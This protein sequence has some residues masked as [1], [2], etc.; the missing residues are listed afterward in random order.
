MAVKGRTHRPV[1]RHERCN[2]CAVCL[3]GCPAEILPEMRGEE[4]SLRGRVYSRRDGALRVHEGKDLG[5]PP[6]QAACPLG[7]DVRG[8]IKLIAE[9]RHADAMALIRETNPL[10]SICGHICPRPCEA[11]CIRGLVDDAVSIRSLKSFVADREG[12]RIEL[13]FKSRAVDKRVSVVGSGP[14]GLSAAHE[15]AA[16][17]YGVEIFESH[18]R[19]GGMLAWAIPDFR[20]PRDALDRDISYIEEMGVMIKTG[21]CFGRDFTLSDLKRGG[22][23]AIIIATGTM[24]P[25]KLGIENEKEC[26]DLVDCLS[27][28]R[29]YAEDKRSLPGERVLVVG[30]GNAAIDSARAAVRLGA[31]MVKLLYRRGPDEMPA[32]PGE[33]QAAILEG[34]GIEYLTA[35]KRIVMKGE[36]LWGME[37]LK[38]ELREDI[39]GGRRSPVVIPGSEFFLE[40]DLIIS[41]VGQEADYGLLA[42]ELPEGKKKEGVCPLDPE[43]MSTPIEGV[44]AAGDFLH[45]PTSVVEAMA[46]GKRVAGRVAGYLSGKE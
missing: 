45:G 19:P 38:T 21:R 5:R 20:L 43:T 42:K 25:L 15:L 23:D 26:E 34:V 30:G 40:G 11:H 18:S 10:P 3:G 2:Q 16:K 12:G 9:G 4:E 29:R 37:C 44:F 28:L 27:F 7:Q 46:S 24:R 22:T 13:H 14:A 32:D 33:V 41:A 39:Q 8:Y 35:P 1:I 36:E 31:G 17:G 6:C